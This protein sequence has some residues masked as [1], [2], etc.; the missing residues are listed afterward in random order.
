LLRRTLA[1]VAFAIGALSGGLL[2][3]HVGVAAA[4]AFGLAIIVGVAIAAHVVSRTPA[5]WTAPQTT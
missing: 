5:S 2:I 4:L 1:L 3:L